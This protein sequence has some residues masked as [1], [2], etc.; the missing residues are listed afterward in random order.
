[1]HLIIM[2]VFWMILY[3]QAMAR[4]THGIVQVVYVHWSH[5]T[6]ALA[7]FTNLFLSDVILCRQH[8]LSLVGLSWAFLGYNYYGVIVLGW[9]PT[10]WFL[11]WHAP[12]KTSILVLFLTAI[13][14]FLFLLL[15]AVNNRVKGRSVDH[16]TKFLLELNKTE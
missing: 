3:N 4:N 10:Y 16:V 1:M 12:L 13:A 9:T 5:I 7:S 14:S 2:P 15:V 6:P 8:L 11:N